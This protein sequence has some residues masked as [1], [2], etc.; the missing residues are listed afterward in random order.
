MIDT[1][2]FSHKNQSLCCPG[3]EGTSYNISVVEERLHQERSGRVTRS[4]L[5]DC[6]N[7]GNIT[8]ESVISVLDTDEDS[9]WTQLVRGAADDRHESPNYAVRD[10]VARYLKE[11]LVLQRLDPLI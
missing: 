6:E 1:S 5:N 11:K 9:T 3:G 2:L 10:E 4:G 7:Q 8:D